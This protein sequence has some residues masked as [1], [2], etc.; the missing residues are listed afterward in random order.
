MS[1][2]T[3]H[4]LDE[5]HRSTRNSCYG[6]LDGLLEQREQINSVERFGVVD[7]GA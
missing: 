4:Y 6:V 2:I 3:T 1:H 5:E 7:G